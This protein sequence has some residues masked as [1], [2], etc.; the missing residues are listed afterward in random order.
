MLLPHELVTVQTWR[1]MAEH[2]RNPVFSPTVLC[3]DE[4]FLSPFTDKELHLGPIEIQGSFARDFSG[5]NLY[6]PGRA[7]RGFKCS[8]TSV[9]LLGTEGMV[10]DCVM[11]LS[12][13]VA[14][15][16]SRPTHEGLRSRVWLEATKA[17]LLIKAYW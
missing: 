10:E 13:S 3:H 7:V 17:V 6:R 9:V 2:N 14:I 1:E 4:P 5:I 16:V 15:F 11:H 8:C 12:S